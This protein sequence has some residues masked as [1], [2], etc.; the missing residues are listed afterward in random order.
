MKTEPRLDGFS[1]VELCNLCTLDALCTEH[2]ENKEAVLVNYA[3]SLVEQ[4]LIE[5]EGHSYHNAQPEVSGHDWTGS[6][7]RRG[8]RS[9]YFLTTVEIREEFV[10]PTYNIA[11]RISGYRFLGQ[12]MIDLRDD[13]DVTLSLKIPKGYAICPSCHFQYN[14][15][16]PCQNH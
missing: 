13:Y 15:A 8:A 12:H 1:I 10:E 11:D 2:Y 9:S 6:V 16:L 14:L 3:H 5:Q 4:N 7:T